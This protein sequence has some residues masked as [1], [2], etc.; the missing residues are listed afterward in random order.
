M[1]GLKFYWM[2]FIPAAVSILTPFILAGEG[3]YPP[4]FEHFWISA[5]KTSV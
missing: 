1:A 5:P 3:I 4:V 2:N